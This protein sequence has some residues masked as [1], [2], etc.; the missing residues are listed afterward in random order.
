MDRMFEPKRLR[1]EIGTDTMDP[2]SNGMHGFTKCQV[3]GNKQMFAA[4]Y[5]AESGSGE[6][7]DAT[8]KSFI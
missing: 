1:T 8:L 6:H 7:I 5:P 2:R 4:A 3:Y